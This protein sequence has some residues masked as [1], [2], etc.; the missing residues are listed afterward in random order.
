MNI[1][2]LS[3]D[4]LSLQCRL[5]GAALLNLTTLDGIPILRPATH[6]LVEPGACALFPM[7]PMANRVA[8]NAFQ[9]RGRTVTLPPSPYDERFFLHGDGWL[10]PWT[11]AA[12]GP[13]SATLALTSALPGVCRYRA[14]L[15]YRLQGRALLASLR[16]TNIGD[17]AFPFGLGFHPFFIKTPAMALSFQ[18]NGYWPEGEHHLPA[19]WRNAPPAEWDFSTPRIPGEAW[20]NNAFSGW[21]GRASLHDGRDGSTVTLSGD[22]GI[23]MVYQPAQSDFIC[24]EPQTHGVNAHNLPEFPGLAILEPGQSLTTAMA[25]SR[26][27]D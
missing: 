12:R 16:I 8:G 25:I 2:T 5:Q 14:E 1:I 17:G 4:C 20:I 18:S 23:L 27:L 22:A 10:R 26:T 15:T 21:R 3:N 24:L 7:L 19:E 13:D 11:L 6:P 9:W